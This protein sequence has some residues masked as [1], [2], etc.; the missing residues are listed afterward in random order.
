[1]RYQKNL[2][3]FV[4]IFLI[5][6]SILILPVSAEDDFAYGSSL[7]TKIDLGVSDLTL[8]AGDTYTFHVT[9]EPENPAFPWLNWFV[10]NDNVVSIDP[11]TAVLTALSAGEARILAEDSEGVAFAICDV[12]VSGGKGYGD[13]TL[14]K[15]TSLITLSE[16]DQK[17]I[18]AP[19]LSRFLE[20]I[21]E[22][23]LSANAAVQASEREFAVPAEVR[24]G[25]EKA[26]ANRA[27]SLGMAKAEPLTHL[28]MVTLQGTF[29]QIMAFAADNPD[30][31]E[32]FDL[33][34]VYFE[35]PIEES[36]DL[37]QKKTALEGH[38]E[39]LTSISTAHSLGFTGK[40]TTIAVLDSGLNYAHPEFAGR[41]KYQA[42]F[43]T[44]KKSGTTVYSSVCSNANYAAP[45]RAKVIGNFNHGSH[46]AGIMAGKN[47]I[48]PE[49]DIVAVQLF[50]EKC[51]D[52]ATAQ[53]CTGKTI[54]SNN[55][56]EAF[57]YLLE[58]SSRGVNITAFNMS[59][60]GGIYSS[61]CNKVRVDAYRT[62][63]EIMELMVNEGKM[64]PVAA[65]GNG[66]YDNLIAQPSC[67]SDVF[68]V[69]ALEDY[70]T[71]VIKYFSNHNELINILAPGTNIY[72]ASYTK[73]GG[74][75]YTIMSGTSMATP[76][77]TGAFAILKQIYPYNSPADL[78][79]L[80]S[81]ITN[82]SVN[83]RNEGYVYDENHD[84]IL[85]PAIT[86]PYDKPVLNFSRLGRFVCPALT[87]NN[88]TVEGL[89]RGFL[90]TIPYDSS[91]YFDIE[92]YDPDKKE[93]VE[94]I[95]YTSEKDP[96]QKYW[97]ITAS[98]S[99]LVN[100]HIYNV[101]ITPYSNIDGTKYYRDSA[102]VNAMPAKPISVTVRPL[103]GSGQMTAVNPSSE[104]RVRFFIYEAETQ[105]LVKTV[106]PAGTKTTG[107]VL[108][109]KSGSLYYAAAQTYKIIDRTNVV[110]G[111]V[112]DPVYFV[113]MS[114]QAGIGIRWKDASTAEITAVKDNLADGFRVLYRPEDGVFSDVCQ[115]PY[116]TVCTV[117]GLDKTGA[118]DFFI[119]KYKNIEGK[120]HSF[121]GP[122]ITLNYR[123]QASGLTP[124]DSPIVT[125]G[126]DNKATVKIVRAKNAEGISVLFRWGNTNDFEYGCE[127]EGDSC[128]IGDIIHSDPNKY[129]TFYVMQYRTVRGHRVYSPGVVVYNYTGPKSA[130][131]DM[132]LAD[133]P[134]EG[135]MIDALDICG[136]LDN[137]M[138]EDDLNRE[139]ISAVL[140]N[141]PAEEWDLSERSM[142]L[143]SVKDFES[144]ETAGGQAA[145]EKA[146]EAG[147]FEFSGEF[148]GEFDA[149]PEY[150]ESEIPVRD[151]ETPVL[152]KNIDRAPSFVLSPDGE[153]DLM[154]LVRK[155]PWGT[156]RTG[157]SAEGSDSVGSASM[158]YRF[159]EQGYLPAP[160][161]NN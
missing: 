73:S 78:E 113:P 137:F 55:E 4:F 144:A 7:I 30:L 133:V 131:Q 91:A 123:T 50:S 120:T 150:W 9:Y 143:R 108:G 61:A 71:P 15:G 21:E 59:F 136:I 26:Q 161:F 16:E 13:Q 39:E 105:K 80:L 99:N 149:F 25:T 145:E 38:V 32:I 35:D 114:T 101:M 12:T 153:P 74:K 106:T 87:E 118:Y 100:D 29:E 66:G 142:F 1:M 103:P 97:L 76:M 111:A 19:V 159:D 60:G 88:V 70:P 6:L 67:D 128:K 126:T 151:E 72:S 115:V 102:V 27:L 47:G 86:F 44:D 156:G 90:I 63:H 51:K 52:K 134:A 98:G 157:A 23:S 10:T 148:D 96:S 139:E 109:L 95:T 132:I 28:H 45:N 129:Y 43:S 104:T 83:Y 64:I 81:L 54:L 155:D 56:L 2:S 152:F 84:P 110:G 124:P 92:I 127:A 160:S 135:G 46:V 37:P 11:D 41:V 14:T 130:D 65:P 121:Y 8:G 58:L 116:G 36:E 75:Y 146:A 3:G 85:V 89:S 147:E 125:I 122:G 79:K 17:K 119:M 112:S 141:D 82:V 69:G 33:L 77:V 20:F 18:T 40:G 48:A 94:G 57:D 53:T 24:P 158:F 5:C 138:T 140:D 42:C 107:I 154:D 93:Y 49:A 31:V 22:S 62:L 117:T 68:A 34:P